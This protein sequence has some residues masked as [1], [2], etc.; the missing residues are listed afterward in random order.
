[1]DSQARALRRGFH[2]IGLSGIGRGGAFDL[3]EAGLLGHAEFIGDGQI[4]RKHR[5]FHCLA[6]GQ[7]RAKPI[8]TASGQSGQADKTTSIHN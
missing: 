2:L 6:D 7:P 3:L 4:L 5:E 1:M 8:A